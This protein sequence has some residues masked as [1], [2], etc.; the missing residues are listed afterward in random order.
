MVIQREQNNQI[1]KEKEWEK[2]T[3]IPSFLFHRKAYI[4]WGVKPQSV[5]MLY[6]TLPHQL[7]HTPQSER[8]RRE[9]ETVKTSNRALNAFSTIT[10]LGFPSSVS[11]WLT[12]WILFQGNWVEKTGRYKWVSS[13]HYVETEVIM[14]KGNRFKERINSFYCRGNKSIASS[15][16]RMFIDMFTKA[17]YRWSQQN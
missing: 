17:Q 14:A 7:K 15:E 11:F 5:K 2:R 10:T 6:S 13:E 1:L 8:S 3:V 16:K 12:I 4:S 9:L